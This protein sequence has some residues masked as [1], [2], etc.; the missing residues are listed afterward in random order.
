MVGFGL[1][2]P[3]VHVSQAMV[4]KLKEV[5]HNPGEQHHAHVVGQGPEHNPG[6]QHH[7]HMVGQGPEHN[8]GE[9]HHAHVIG[10]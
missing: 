3:E 1:A 10:Q 7:A 4:G 9:Q 2:I 6:E 8:P 5:R